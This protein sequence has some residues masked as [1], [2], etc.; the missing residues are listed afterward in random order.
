VCVQA[1]FKTP[2]ILRETA[3][4]YCHGLH[5]TWHLSIVRVGHGIHLIIIKLYTHS[6]LLSVFYPFMLSLPFP[7]FFLAFLTHTHT[8]LHTFNDLWYPVTQLLCTNHTFK[9][10]C[11]LTGREKQPLL[12]RLTGSQYYQHFFNRAKVNRY[13]FNRC[14]ERHS[15]DKRD[16]ILQSGG[17]W[18]HPNSNYYTSQNTSSSSSTPTLTLLMLT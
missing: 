3:D 16:K 10:V 6:M 17:R 13:N 4:K 5:V 11:V 7:H 14:R 15:Q 12:S 2:E 8:H 1:W 9:C 18:H